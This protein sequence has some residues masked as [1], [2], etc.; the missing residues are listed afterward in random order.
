M[1]RNLIRR[2]FCFKEDERGVQLV[3][4]AIV[5]P[6]VILLFAAAAEFGRYFYE[7]TTLAKGTRV[8]ARYL[9]TAASDGNDDPCA[10]NL[11]VY[12]NLGGTGN[13]IVTGLTPANVQITRRNLAGTIIT[14]GIPY[15][16][17][18][19]IINYPHTSILD[20]GRLTNSTATLSIDVK[21]SVTMHYLLTQ[22]PIATGP[23]F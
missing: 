8:A 12:G 23:C 7:Y 2:L 17:T 15:T 22:P 16:V 3:E 5:L 4:L 9:A 6:V 20:L 13:P 18:V 14:G 19:D 21:P 1:S 10:K 11:V